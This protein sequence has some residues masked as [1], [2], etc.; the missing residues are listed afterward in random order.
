MFDVRRQI[1]DFEANVDNCDITAGNYAFLK[2]QIYSEFNQKPFSHNW[3][4]DLYPA[5]EK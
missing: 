1:C 4:E 2:F 5:M 3:E